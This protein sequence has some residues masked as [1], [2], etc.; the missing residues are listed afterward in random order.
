M[1][2]KIIVVGII[3]A[4]IILLSLNNERNFDS[5]VFIKEC[6]CNR[7]MQCQTDFWCEIQQNEQCGT[8]K[9]IPTALGGSSPSPKQ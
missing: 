9:V 4:V 1:K 8:C 2:K 6:D 3:L 5:P 7:E